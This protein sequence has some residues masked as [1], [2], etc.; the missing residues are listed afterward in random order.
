MIFKQIQR[1]RPDR[2]A[3]TKDEHRFFGL[4]GNLLPM[5]LKWL[6][7]LP[8]NI[9]RLKWH[10]HQFQEENAT[11]DASS[12]P[13]GPF[14]T[15][16][17]DQ[18]GDLLLW[19]PRGLD[20]DLIDAM[21]G[22]YGYSHVTIDTGENDLPT[23]KPVMLVSTLGQKVTRRFQDEYKRR[24]FVRAPISKTGVNVK[25]FV[26]CVKSKMGEQYDIL[27]AITFGEIE[28]PVKQVCSRL[29][30][31]YLPENERLQIERARKM[32]L[33]C[34]ASVSIYSRP[35]KSKTR[36][37]ISPNGFAEYYGAPKG[38]NLSGLETT[39]E[40]QQVKLAVRCVVA[41]S[42]RQHVWKFLAIA[43]SATCLL[44]YCLYDAE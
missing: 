12:L 25:H 3:I 1:Y 17:K 13:T 26:E 14:A 37:F 4:I 28:D 21:S 27:D 8:L 19:V 34:K 42:S 44:I 16:R 38:R 39:L 43:G 23:G 9:H 40:S 31:D 15:T 2:H 18:L 41:A 29:V 35:G 33:V 20:S 6:R 24:A 10:N 7:H 22:G 11:N 5:Q 30:A 32:G 36:G